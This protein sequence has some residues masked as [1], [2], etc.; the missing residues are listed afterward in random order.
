VFVNL[1]GY[2]SEHNVDVARSLCRHLMYIS[3]PRESYLFDQQMADESENLR[4]NKTS[5]RML[6]R[7]NIL[8]TISP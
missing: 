5:E 3:F 1:D 7:Y 2:E 4:R 8:P 6:S